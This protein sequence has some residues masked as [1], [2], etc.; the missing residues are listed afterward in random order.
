MSD[1][2][3]TVDGIT[4][5]VEANRLDFIAD[6]PNFERPERV[7][8]FFNNPTADLKLD[9]HVLKVLTHEVN[10]DGEPTRLHIQY[11]RRKLVLGRRWKSPGPVSFYRSLEPTNAANRPKTAEE[12]SAALGAFAQ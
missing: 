6:G 10:A 3:P 1:F 8:A 9:G 2:K 4:V 12:I 5:F 7:S 11:G